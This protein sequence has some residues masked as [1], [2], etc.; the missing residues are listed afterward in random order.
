[1]RNI[2]LSF[3]FLISII[4]VLVYMAAA[5]GSPLAAFILGIL[6]AGTLLALG[7]GASIL[8]NHIATK[9]RQADFINNA[10]ENLAIMQRMQAIQN[11]QNTQLLRQVKQL[12]AGSS[13]HQPELVIDDAVFS[14]LED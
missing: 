5:Q 7:Q 4:A 12:P 13:D 11:Q 1:M 10:R 6:T 14:Q 9:H 3:I 2:A 8:Q